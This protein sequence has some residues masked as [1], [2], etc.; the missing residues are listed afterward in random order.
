M[1]L[2]RTSNPIFGKKTFEQ[3]YTSTYGDEQMT[4]NGTINKTALVLLF[5]ISTAFYTWQKFFEVYN[6]ADPSLAVSSVMKYLLIGGIGG[7]IIAIVATFTPK[8]SG[9]T[10]P[11]YAIFEGMFL[12]G[13]SAMFEAQFPGLVIKAVALT[14]AVFLSMLFIYRQGIIKVTGKF[15]RGMLSA[16][17][18]L[19]MVY[20]VSWIAGMFGADVSYLYG[21]GTF[22]L[23]FSLIVTGISAFSLMLDFDFIEQNAAARAP[24]YMEWYSVF[25][26]L[27]S[28]VWLY[29][30]ILRLLSILSRRN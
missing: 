19:M 8:W 25:G 21:G 27:V 28:L 2:T 23:I 26:L 10:T 24:K 7:F 20:L 1:N 5:V 4:L 30:N 3:A 18:G 17:F 22:G 13:L 9:F 6:P 12:G 15:K 16:M 11:I 29:V 14:F